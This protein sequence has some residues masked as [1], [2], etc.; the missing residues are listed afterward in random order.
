LPWMQLVQ[1][2]GVSGSSLL[3][4]ISIPLTIPSRFSLFTNSLLAWPSHQCQ[5]VSVA[6]DFLVWAV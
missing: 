2:F 3:L 4:L 1:S 6:V 5:I